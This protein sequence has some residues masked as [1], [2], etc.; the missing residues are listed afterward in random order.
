MFGIGT[1]LLLFHGE[2]YIQGKQNKSFETERLTNVEPI[3]NIAKLRYPF[4]K[5]LKLV[6]ENRKRQI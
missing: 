2:S 5:M 4:V 3:T 6:S 1:V